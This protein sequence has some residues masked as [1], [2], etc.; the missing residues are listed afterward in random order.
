MKRRD[1]GAAL[2]ATA[3]SAALRA[4]EP[5]ADW[6]IGYAGLQADLAPMPLTLR[7]RWPAGLEGTLLRNGTG[8][9]ELGG[10]RYRHPF[11]GDGMIQRWRVADGRVV[12]D[13]RF[14]RTPKFLADSAAG[15]PV[16]DAFATVVPNAEPVRSA[17]AMNVANTSVI[18]HGG[19]LLALWEGGSAMRLDPATLDTR[20]FKTWAPALAGLPCSAHPRVE[21]D[22]TLWNFGIASRLGRM[23]VWRVDGRGALQQH[24]LL[25]VPNVAMVHD[26]AVTEHHLVFLLPPLVWDAARAESGRSFLDSHAW[27]PELGLR[28]MV[29]PKERLD[30]PRWF[31]LPAGFVFHIGNAWEDGSTIR[32]DFMRTPD[33]WHAMQGLVQ[34]MQGRHVP[35]AYATM[36]TA[37]LDLSSGR[38]AQQP[39]PTVAEFPRIDPRLTGRRHRHVFAA[40]RID[41]EGRPGYDGVQRFDLDGGA[42]DRFHYGAYVMAEEH[43]FVPGGERGWVIG[44]AL[45]LREQAMK[46]SVF[47]AGALADGPLA[48]ATLARVLPLGLHAAWVPAAG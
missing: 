19:E 14:V 33:A 23:V 39:W 45:D 47:D 24:A 48:Q 15:R 12:H 22:G 7:G 17:D 10:L 20:G 31:E 11:D 32:L 30:A 8:R 46:L 37:A 40:A 13:A 21:A 9:H 29:L 18:D 25:Q 6:R 35:H 41:C 27:R 4:Q 26:F 42:I 16:R 3:A 2:L 5:G 34:L 44:T 28:A 1:F 43:V 36:T 38:A